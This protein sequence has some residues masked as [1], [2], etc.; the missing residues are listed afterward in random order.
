M[1]TKSNS[2]YLCLLGCLTIGFPACSQTDGGGGGGS[3][4]SSSGGSSGAGGTTSS[5][6]TS[7]SGGTTATGGSSTTGGTT[8]SGGAQGGGTTTA[9]GGKSTG[10]QTSTGGTSA[11]GGSAGDQGTGGLPSTGGSTTGPRL[12]GGPGGAGG[13][14]GT[15]TGMRDGG[16]GSGGTSGSGGTTGIGGSAGGSTGTGDCVKGQTKGNE[17]VIIGES[18]IAAGSIP[19]ELEKL[20][21]AAGS[22]ASSEKYIMNAVSGTLLSGGASNS[23][24]KQFASAAASN[25]LKYVVMDG[26]GNDCLQANNGDAALTAATALFKDMQ[27]EGIQKIMYFFYPDPLGSFASGN[28]KPC[29]DALRPK[30][31]ALC[32]GLTAPK[33]YWLDLRPTWN[34]HS[35]YTSDGIHPTAAGSV[36][37]AKAI[38]D[39]MVKNCIAQ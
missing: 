2:W 5:G 10:G 16:P 6:G 21:K 3:G 1:R 11:A 33:C 29:L 9:T 32:E 4:G 24:P 17:V 34:G 31:Q 38:W 23:I 30:M 37:S 7:A 39:V 35:E 13:R 12:D 19:T 26:G 8:S 20:A 27:T 22:L 15:G 28:L 18:F 25:T 36:A 14:T